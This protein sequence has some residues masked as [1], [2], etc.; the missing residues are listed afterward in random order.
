MST[1]A[2]DTN[3][4]VVLYNTSWS[5]YEQISNAVHEQSRAHV[6]FDRGTLEIM[7]LSFKHE[8][9]G[10]LLETI[11]EAIALEFDIDF[12]AAG[13]TT[14]KR[15][16]LERGFEPDGCYY[17]QDAAMMRKKNEVNLEFDPPPD[18]SI[19]IDI[20]RSSIKR[21]NLFAAIGI[22]EVWRLKKGKVEI[23]ILRSGQYELTD[24][25]SVLTGLDCETLNDL[26][27]KAPTLSHRDLLKT[28]SEYCRKFQ[29]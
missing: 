16:D 24:R 3:Q 13:S 19:E 26:L 9:L 7:T 22:G 23:H 2:L 28:V 14:F 25:S 11:F 29:N 21:M 18:F 6:T 1:L 27:D 20:T 12:V 4:S 10:R 8:R 15:E 5:A 17:V